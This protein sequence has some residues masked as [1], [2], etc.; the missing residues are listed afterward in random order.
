MQRAMNENGEQLLLIGA[1]AGRQ[2][3]EICIES[4]IAG[5]AHETD[6]LPA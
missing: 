3:P 6:E 2:I 5:G 1:W 4:K